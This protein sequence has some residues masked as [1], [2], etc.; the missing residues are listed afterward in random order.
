MTLGFRVGEHRRNKPFW[1]GG[2]QHRI[3]GRFPTICSHSKAKI[4]QKRGVPTPGPSHS[5]IL[6]STTDED[7]EDRY[8]FDIKPCFQI[9]VW[10]YFTVSEHIPVSTFD[11]TKTLNNFIVKSCYNRD[12]ALKYLVFH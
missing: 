9:G 6:G 7:D 2:F 5:P 3:K 4:F 12:M 8:L 10:Q 11:F 1:K